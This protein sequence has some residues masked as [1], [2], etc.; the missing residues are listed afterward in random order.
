LRAALRS[1][2]NVDRWVATQCLAHCGVC[3]SEVAGELVNQ[4]M[5][6]EDAIR[7]EQATHLLALLSQDT[8]NS[9]SPNVSIFYLK[10]SNGRPNKLQM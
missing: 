10:I 3:D 1:N 5:T 2:S 4:L 7:H 9:V 8:A 6:S